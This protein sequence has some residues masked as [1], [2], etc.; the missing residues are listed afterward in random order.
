MTKAEVEVFS[1]LGNDVVIR[2]PG[3]KFP[4]VLVQGDS[5]SVLVRLA[6]A[7]QQLSARLDDEELRDIT[8]ELSELLMNKLL[9]YEDALAKHGIRLPYSR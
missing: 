6:T 9:W 7:A 8:V 4:G 3:R 1:P 5:L 2:M